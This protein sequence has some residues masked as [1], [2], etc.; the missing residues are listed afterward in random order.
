MSKL[1]F[2]LLCTPLISGSILL[3]IPKKDIYLIREIS[4]VSS[5][6]VLLCTVFLWSKFD[7][8]TSNFQFSYCSNNYILKNFYLQFILGVDG[9]SMI[10]ILL[11]AFIIPLCLWSVWHK[12][13]I[14]LNLYISLFLFLE[15]AILGSFLSLDL[16]LF[17]IFFEIILIPMIFL[18]GI[19][20]SSFKKIRAMYLFLLYTAC[21]SLFIF[22]AIF[23]II[24]EKQTTNFYYLFYNTLPFTKEKQI[25]L[26]F[27]FFIGLSVKIPVFPLH[28]WLPEAHVEASTEGS[29]ILASLLLKLGGYGFLRTSLPLCPNATI[30]F[31]PLLYT[32][33]ISGI[34]FCSFVALRQNDFKKIVAYSSVAHMNLLVLGI[35]STNIQGLQG[36]IFLMVGHAVVSSGLFFLIGCLYDRHK[37]RLIGY[38]GN[39]LQTMPLLSFFFFLYSLTNV[40]FP[41]TCNF[42]G[43][44][45][46]LIS[47]F[48]VNSF[49]MFISALSGI[50]TIAYTFW[51]LNRLIFGTVKLNYMK[52]YTDLVLWELDI[53]FYFSILIIIL[54]LRPSYILDISYMSSLHLLQ[55]FTIG[56]IA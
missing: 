30:Y 9:F 38:F 46:I 33:A 22:F 50:L 35:F 20:G 54:G 26:W 28:I 6:L 32:F 51:L 31:L 8:M 53:V 12:K 4:I 52:Y 16:L 49:I 10:F 11:T 5:F 7:T 41:G 36:G 48:E 29:I 24:L 34:I 47:I 23:L 37:V 44:I 17:F 1:L 18:I 43:E 21:G 13:I 3:F 27:L 40:S 19:W 42:V 15:F 14:F 45:L 56:C 25:I 55:F 39:L 2:I